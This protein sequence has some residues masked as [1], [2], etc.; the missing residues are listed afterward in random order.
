LTRI[1]FD[2]TLSESA[3]SFHD[4]C[5][6]GRFLHEYDIPRK[7]LAGIPR[8]ILIEM[9]HNREGALCCGAGGGLKSHFPEVALQ[10]GEQRIKEF[11]DTL[12]STLVTTCIFCRHNLK[13]G[14]DKLKSNAKVQ[15]LE[16]FLS[17]R[18][19]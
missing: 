14:I 17:D 2:T 3:V 13:E 10:I 4:P 18:L 5:H 19:S 9:A 16:E 7:V 8:T 11:H 6:I 12:A 15:L 1:R